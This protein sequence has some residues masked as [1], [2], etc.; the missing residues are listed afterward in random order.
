MSAVQWARK[1]GSCHSDS[2]S[3]VGVG[4][5]QKQ[6]VVGVVRVVA[7]QILLQGGVCGVTLKTHGSWDSEGS[8][9]SDSASEVEV[10]SLQKQTVVG[11]CE[12]S[13]H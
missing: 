9:H 12:G 7:I 4:S 11:V 6:T 2:T 8:C 5:F 1:K 3:E 10:G 13:C